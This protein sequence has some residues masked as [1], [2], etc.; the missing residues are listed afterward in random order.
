M[1]C[2]KS[3]SLAGN[4]VQEI[5]GGR[6]N[7]NPV[8]QLIGELTIQIDGAKSAWRSQEE[9]AREAGDRSLSDK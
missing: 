7:E 9:C 8:R 5:K 3:A 1:V 4:P 2:S 6:K